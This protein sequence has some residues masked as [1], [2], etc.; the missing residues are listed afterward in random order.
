MGEMLLFTVGNLVLNLEAG[1]RGTGC[2]ELNLRKS[3]KS[4]PKVPNSAVK[5]T[6]FSGILGS[7]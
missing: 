1:L 7:R 6:G 2:T 5:P 3:D 4:D